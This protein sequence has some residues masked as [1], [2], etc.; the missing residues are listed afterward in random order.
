MVKVFCIFRFSIYKDEPED[1]EEAS[2]EKDAAD[3]DI[4][5]YRSTKSSLSDFNSDKSSSFSLSSANS[6]KPQATNKYEEKKS[7]NKVDLGAAATLVSVARNAGESQASGN[8]PNQHNQHSSRI[9]AGQT[10]MSDLVDLMNTEPNDAPLVPMN[11]PEEPD[12]F[13]GFAGAPATGSYF[14]FYL[15]SEIESQFGD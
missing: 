9:N 14:L 10:A 8:G 7:M 13:G 6:S 5:A 15:F 2:E 1:G 12:L 3:E 11:K 4:F